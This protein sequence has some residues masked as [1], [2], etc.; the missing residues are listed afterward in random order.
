MV[1]CRTVTMGAK[2]AFSKYQ[3]ALIALQDAVA[4]ER[5]HHRTVAADREAKLA[6]E[7]RA[8]EK[9]QLKKG[10]AAAPAPMGKE[11]STADGGD[12]DNSPPQ[13]LARRPTA[14]YKNFP[15]PPPPAPSSARHDSAL[16]DPRDLSPDAP[17]AV[18]PSAAASPD[19]LA[20]VASPP[21]G[22][23]AE[24]THSP[25]EGGNGNDS[26]GERSDFGDGCQQNTSEFFNE[27]WGP[28]GDASASAKGTAARSVSIPQPGRSGRHE[29]EA[30]DDA[31]D[32][33]PLI[34]GAAK[35]DAAK[36]RELFTSEERAERAA[37][38]GAPLPPL[39]TRP[40]LFNIFAK[41]VSL[42]GLRQEELRTAA[43]E[44][45][46]ELAELE[47]GGSY[48][49][50]V[51]VVFEDAACAVE[52]CEV[53]AHRFSTGVTTVAP[54]TVDGAKP[55]KVTSL[56]PVT[57]VL[58]GP[59][60]EVHRSSLN[61]N[62]IAARTFF[63]VS[64]ALFVWL[65]FFYSIPVAALSSLEA[66]TQLPYGIGEWLD[67][68]IISHMSVTVRGTVQAY[69]PVIV[70]AVFHAV[71]PIFVRASVIASGTPNVEET[72]TWQSLLMFLF[73]FLT[74]V[75]FQAVLQGGFSQ[76]GALI[77]DPQWET[78]SAM[79]VAV[80]SPAGGYWYALV[81]GSF[82]GM[83]V[84]ALN[85]GPLLKALVLS[86]FATSQHSYDALFARAVPKTQ[87]LFP[88]ALVMLAIGILFHATVPVLALACGVF[89]LFAYVAARGV[90]LDI[91]KSPLHNTRQR[92][93][94]FGMLR[95]GL[96]CVSVL[97][98]VATVGLV[99]AMLVK[100]VWWPPFIVLAICLPS[101]AFVII[102]VFLKTALWHPSALLLRAW[103]EEDEA[104]GFDF[105]SRIVGA[106]L[107]RGGLG[108]ARKSALS[109]LS[110]QRA[111]DGEGGKVTSGTDDDD[112]D[113]E[114]FIF[115]MPAVSAS[116]A[117]VGGGAEGSRVSS[118]AA[119]PLALDGSANGDP[120]GPAPAIVIGGAA[121]ERDDAGRRGGAATEKRMVISKPPAAAAAASSMEATV[122]VPDQSF[123]VDASTVFSAYEYD[124]PTSAAPA[125]S[126]RAAS[127]NSA[128]DKKEGAD[129][130]DDDGPA[131]IL[132]LEGAVERDDA[133][134]MAFN[135]SRRMQIDKLDDAASVC[136]SYSAARNPSVLAPSPSGSPPLAARRVTYLHSPAM[137]FA[138]HQPSNLAGRGGSES[139][140]L[141]EDNPNYVS[142]YPTRSSFAAGPFFAGSDAASASAS[143]SVASPHGPYAGRQSFGVSIGNFSRSAGA[144]AGGGLA[145]SVVVSPFWRMRFA[146][147]ADKPWDYHSKIERLVLA[148]AAASAAAAAR[149]RRRA[150]V[151]HANSPAAQS[152]FAGAASPQQQP[153][154]QAPP[155]T[156]I[157]PIDNNSN[158]NSAAEKA[159]QKRGTANA[160]ALF[161]DVDGQIEAAL[162][163][164]Y[165]VARYW[166]GTVTGDGADGAEWLMASSSLQQQQTVIVLDGDAER[167]DV[168][169]G[170]GAEAGQ[171][172]PASPALHGTT[173]GLGRSVAFATQFNGDGSLALRPHP[174]AAAAP[175]AS[176]GSR[177][178]GAASFAYVYDLSSE[179]NQRE[180]NARRRFI[181]VQEGANTPPLLSASNFGR[182]NNA[183]SPNS[184]KRRNESAS[185]YSYAYPMPSHGMHGHAGVGGRAGQNV[186]A[187][188]RDKFINTLF[189]ASRRK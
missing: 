162:A 171:P 12:G 168:G 80:V 61:I 44:L 156:A 188:E 129:S 79:L 13:A 4:K 160:Y 176:E 149:E 43:K 58:A 189:E 66:L 75:V 179:A 157:V 141:G 67:E 90:F 63:L 55:R 74:S 91:Y 163:A 175:S 25:K 126:V 28:N 136:L 82:I 115:N 159:Q 47:S 166:H 15:A 89:F 21:E 124:Y 6:K 185:G 105:S 5:E 54:P 37:I 1:P 57:A 40:S 103:A 152:L 111:R 34:G 165:T 174:T 170:A 95:Y 102:Y 62:T 148:Y 177:S 118:P 116:F 158:S 39:L 125:P 96:R 164:T 123:F 155:F 41:K 127:A 180:E 64:M 140:I 32:S 153:A 9:K 8:R 161:I 36:E 112:S 23:G 78:V 51:F 20:D 87:A 30:N 106:S 56:M 121:A 122:Y 10:G 187:N 35:D 114:G 49:G 31:S 100:R 132:L 33:E 167:C 29:E 17:T 65:V 98:A 133:V 16:V 48:N 172:S 130:D 181:Y 169:R 68:A 19:R 70:L 150:R 131:P 139:A 69:L 178:P 11:E 52:F 81:M 143:A 24:N 45:S 93:S 27:Q 137:S 7:L 73:A 60:D 151:S 76:L 88:S 86:R 59:P 109:S 146:A 94:S 72:N 97:Y 18:P 104:A 53:V 71:L 138:S 128:N 113:D 38:R 110:A 186:S 108:S 46:S 26:D 99:F 107:R 184:G 182:P 84:M 83:W 85:V 14:S 77:E 3:S 154:S 101:S 145:H 183:A 144:G 42:V 117:G 147:F 22:E 92:V 120:D 135:Q 134:I 2:V 142:Y 50:A 119:P 173:R